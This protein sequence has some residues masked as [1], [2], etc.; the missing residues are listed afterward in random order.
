MFLLDSH[1]ISSTFYRI[2]ND[3]II[4]LRSIQWEEIIISFL[5]KVATLVFLIF[6]YFLLKKGGLYFIKNTL[7][8]NSRHK[9]RMKTMHSLVSNIYRY[10]LGFFLIYGVL[11]TFNVPVNSIL[12]WMGFFEATIGLGSQ[13]LIKDVITGLFI[14][15]EKQINVGD[16]IRLQDEIEGT[17][18]SIGIRSMQI[19]SDNGTAIFI[20]NGSIDIVKTF[21]FMTDVSL[22]TSGFSQTVIFIVSNKLWKASTSYFK[23]KTTESLKSLES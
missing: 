16:Y 7:Q 3:I 4:A 17:V 20:P 9:N 12:V 19:R 15:I 6:I 5:H 8:E 13:S 18:I 10:L 2:K 1:I 11:S 22:L 14:L 23:T 21:H